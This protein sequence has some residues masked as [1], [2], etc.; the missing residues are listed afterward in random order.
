[1][2]LSTATPVEID[3]VIAAIYVRFYAAADKARTM[4]DHLQAEERRLAQV[5]AGTYR[6]AMSERSIE[7]L[8]ESVKTLTEKV[9]D[10]NAAAAAIM[11]ETA[12]YNEEFKARGGWS[13]FYLVDNSG[14]HVHS[15]MHCQSC[16][17]TTQFIW[18]P[19]H[20]GDTN[21]RIIEKANEQACTHCFPGA[22]VDPSR[23][24]GFEAPARKA[25]RE[26]R[27]AKAAAALAKRI[28]KSLSLDGSEVRIV[29]ES[30][31]RGDD[32]WHAPSRGKA[33]T[34]TETFKAFVTAMSWVVDQK[35][36]P[37]TWSSGDD[38]MYPEAVQ[39]VTEMLAAKRGV[40]VEEITAEINAKVAKKVKTFHR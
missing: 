27:D 40:T 7:S 5:E 1:M 2:N 21:E 10:L 4:A 25:A 30:G 24:G 38:V 28:Q 9:A 36:A 15:S 12:P 17:P 16:Y 23:K 14:G 11:R 22:P 35:A 19:E 6:Y 32:Y 39:Q 18:L 3:T 33:W 37:L 8:R 26:E 20:S 13:R 34:K 29:L 31:V